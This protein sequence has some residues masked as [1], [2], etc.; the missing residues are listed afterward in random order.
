MKTYGANELMSQP[1]NPTLLDDSINIKV[2]KNQASKTKKGK[3]SLSAN[4]TTRKTVR[5]PDLPKRPTNAYLMFCEREKENIKN[6]LTVNNLGKSTGELSRILTDTWKGLDEEQKKPYQLLYE[7]DRERYK[8]EMEEY[9]KRKQ[10]QNSASP[11]KSEISISMEVS[12]I[13]HTS[14]ELESKDFKRQ[15]LETSLDPNLEVREIGA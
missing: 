5:D 9:N 11:S 1:P 6:Q 14:D 4:G 12:D 15:R 2:V 7:E 13:K 3:I 10:D 8:K